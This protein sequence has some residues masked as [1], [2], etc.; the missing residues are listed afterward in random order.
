MQ[1][2]ISR[3]SSPFEHLKDTACEPWHRHSTALRLDTYRLFVAISSLWVRSVV[4]EKSNLHLGVAE[5]R[6]KRFKCN[7]RVLP[8]LPFIITN[9]RPNTRGKRDATRASWHVE[10]NGDLER[11]AGTLSACASSAAGTP[12]IQCGTPKL[13]E[14]G[15]NI[16]KCHCR[17]V[18]VAEQHLAQSVG[19][20][21]LFDRNAFVRIT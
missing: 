10:V 2:R 21:V 6:T 12:Q 13:I 4:Q 3:I 11:V 16:G 7:S 17:E 18:H 9:K 5:L 15:R 19:Q 8:L 14:I 1:T 20:D